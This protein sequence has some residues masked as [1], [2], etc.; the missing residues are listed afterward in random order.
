MCGLAGLLRTDG[1]RADLDVV[2]RMGEALRHRGPD[3][4]GSFAD[5]PLA[6]AHR[7]LSII[8]LSAAGSQPMR[9]PDGRYT[10]V[11]NGEIY[12]YRELR[13]E[14]E[15]EGWRFRSRSDTEVLLA[16]IALWGIDRLALRMDGM[17]AFALWD[18]V[19]RRLTLVRDRFGVKPLYLWRAPWGIAFASEIKAFL[20]HPDF[21]AA[22][23]RSA[24]AEYFTFQ[25]L[26]RVTH[27]LLRRRA[28]AARRDHGIRPRGRAGANLLGLRF[29]TARRD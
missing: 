22:V 8:D 14:L 1:G 29:F 2:V 20:Q 21:K 6:L 19:E 11:Y 28:G 16:G 5:G 26:F 13:A 4:E 9:T 7:R 12:N 10:I 18:N 3:G 24:L 17:A 25:N 27:A 15:R 23:N